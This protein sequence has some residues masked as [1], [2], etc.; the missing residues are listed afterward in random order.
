MKTQKTEKSLP[1]T[2]STTLEADEFREFKVRSLHGYKG[3]DSQDYMEVVT[4]L[5]IGLLHRD[6]CNEI[7]VKVGDRPETNVLPLRS[8]R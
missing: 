1:C 5:G 6:D 8:F 4:N 7:E 2:D 3:T